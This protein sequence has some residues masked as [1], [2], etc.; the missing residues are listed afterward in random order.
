MG[1]YT[2]GSE[3]HAKKQNS[4]GKGWHGQDHVFFDFKASPFK[5]FCGIEE[6]AASCPYCCPK[7]WNVT[8]FFAGFVFTNLKIRTIKPLSP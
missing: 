7:T 2:N 6:A 8:A 4:C 1:L 3:C 5:F